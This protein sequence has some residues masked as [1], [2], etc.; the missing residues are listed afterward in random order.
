MNGAAQSMYCKN[1]GVAC[2]MPHTNLIGLLNARSVCNK[3]SLV[4]DHIIDHDLDVLIITETWMTKNNAGR[5]KAELIPE[6]YSSMNQ[7]RENKRGGGLTVL[8]KN[9]FT[10]KQVKST[11]QPSSFEI[12]DINLSVENSCLR[13][14]AIYRPPGPCDAFHDEF[15]NLLTQLASSRNRVLVAGDFNIP[16]EKSTDR[17]T[18]KLRSA[19]EEVAFTQHVNQQTHV[20]GHT[21]D[22]VI[23]K[24]DVVASTSVA[25]LVSDHFAVHATLNFAKISRQRKV[26]T[27]RCLKRLDH[28]A[29]SEEAERSLQAITIP[30]SATDYAVKLDATL[31]SVLDKLAPKE[32]RTMTI[33]PNSQWMTDEILQAKR[34]KRRSERQWRKSGLQSHFIA[35]QEKRNQLTSMI[36]TAKSTYEHDRIASCG[37]DQRALFRHVQTLLNHDD[38]AACPLSASQLSDFFTRKIAQIRLSFNDTAYSPH[39]LDRNMP[40][41]LSRFKTVTLEETNRVIHASPTKSCDLDPWPAWILK[42]HLQ[43]VAPALT[44]LINCSLLSG[45]FPQSWKM[46]LITPI[47]KKPS[48][49]PSQPSSYRPVS[50]LPFAS[51]VLERIVNTQLSDYLNHHGLHHPFQSAYRAQH[52][53]ETALLKVQNDIF[54]AVDQ[55]KSVALI[56]LDLS[57]AFDTVDHEI[58]LKRMQKKFGIDAAVLKWMRSYLSGREQ[59]VKVGDDV[60][61]PTVMQCG[62]PQGSVLGPVLFSLYVSPLFDIAQQCGVETHQYADDC[63]LYIS[64]NAQDPDAVDAAKEKLE[65]CVKDIANWMGAN[66]LQLNDSKSEVIV[67]SPPK[68]E[69]PPVL[70]S[71]NICEANVTIAASVRDLGVLFTANLSAERQVNA[72]SAA[73]Y[74]HLSNISAIRKC[75]TKDATEKLIHAFISSKLDFC[76]SL[77]VNLPAQLISKL[78]RVQN[79]AA[80]IITG[81]PRREHITPILQQLH[82][83]PVQQR[84]DFKTLLLTWKAANAEAPVYLQNLIQPYQ[85]SRNLRSGNDGL[86]VQPIVRTNAGKRTF[87]YAGPVLWNNLPASIRS[88]NSAKDFKTKLKTHLFNVAFIH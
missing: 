40:S 86:L 18:M 11:A 16:W 57:A 35:Y 45:E 32:T 33:R 62:V 70:N 24:G 80:R 72:M 14:L 84:I 3:A 20:A 39:A 17:D 66:K 67:F 1:V 8:F 47:V 19:L 23:S 22:L 51:K 13:L 65:A 7:M 75:L 5:V 48:L 42:K 58:L 83:L 9:K 50:N 21:I 71:F 49:D 43:I 4:S 85:P 55:R 44:D 34:E 82:W 6:G 54:E 15:S 10:A 26:I 69:T 28:N 59:K 61:A 46:A 64:M 37:H 76:N 41:S 12:L 2:Q 29:L 63:Q 74:F 53:V 56:L 31:L 27:S 77:L 25:D 81:T 52:S 88:S 68:I 87:A 79:A 73:C 60:S 30:S 78:Q 38:G 36:Q